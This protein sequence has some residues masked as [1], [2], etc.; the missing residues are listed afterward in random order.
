MQRLIM[1]ISICHTS[2][3]NQKKTKLVLYFYQFINT[4]S[5]FILLIK[6][7]EFFN[8]QLPKHF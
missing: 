8:N 1:M 3:K 7:K 6:C 4:S 2:T 5:S